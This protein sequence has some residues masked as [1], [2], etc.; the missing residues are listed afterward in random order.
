MSLHG[1]H[2]AG[3]GQLPS[4]E[5]LWP[6]VWGRVFRVLIVPLM[7]MRAAALPTLTLAMT[8]LNRM[9]LPTGHNVTLCPTLA[10]NVS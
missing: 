5:L 9:S 1:C 7:C 3:W 8:V 6:E 4:V 10:S 2:W